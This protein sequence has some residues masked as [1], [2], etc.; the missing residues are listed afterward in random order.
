MLVV[1]GLS[2]VGMALRRRGMMVVMIDPGRLPMM[3]GKLIQ[4]RCE[5][6]AR[7]ALRSGLFRVALFFCL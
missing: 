2:V 4:K 7:G 1:G 6:V 5:L 3:M